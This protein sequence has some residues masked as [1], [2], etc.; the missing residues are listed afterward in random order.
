MG[1]PLHAWTPTAGHQSS[2]LVILDSYSVGMPQ[3]SGQ[4]PV[5][6]LQPVRGSMEVVTRS[7][8]VVSA[9]V[10]VALLFV[11]AAAAGVAGGGQPTTSEA[12]ATASGVANGLGG[13][14]WTGSLVVAVVSAGGVWVIYTLLP[15][16]FRRRGRR[17]YVKRP[18][19][20]WPVLV[21]ATVAVSSAFF[22]GLS[23]LIRGKAPHLPEGGGAR[24]PLLGGLPRLPGTSTAAGGGGGSGVSWIAIAAG[25]LVAILAIIAAQLLRRRRMGQGQRSG[26]LP[27]RV[28]E[29]QRRQVV[30]VLDESLEALEAEP[31]PRQAVIAAY[32]CMDRWLARA[33]FGRKSWE[34]PFE[35]LDRIVGSLGATTAVGG[36]LAGL[37]ER[38]K[39]DYR[40]C[41]PEMKQAALNALVQ[42]RDELASLASE[43]ANGAA[44]ADN[45][46]ASAGPGAGGGS[47]P[48]PA[49]SS[50]RPPAQPSPARSGDGRVSLT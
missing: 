40:P 16:L 31:D 21:A 13:P 28:L 41:G 17:R 3:A 2:L 36:T 10:A 22:A 5:G 18:W 43:G 15:G 35:H 38:A 6:N 39:F 1:T 9:A 8:A 25:A 14:A 19:W 7:K 23:W 32:I 34:A 26:G 48:G 29:E 45:L 12:G 44:A 33:G 47:G 20:Y 42:L 4:G 46:A 24:T 50:H 49:G 30:E 37:Y 27:R 11:V